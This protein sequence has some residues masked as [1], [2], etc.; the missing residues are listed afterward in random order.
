MSHQYNQNS[1]LAWWSAR[2][3]QLPLE[4]LTPA[5][6]G[7][8]RDKLCRGRSG[9]TV[10]R[11]LAAL[12]AV[13]SEA[14]REWMWL[15]QNSVRRVRRP[16]EARARV[17]FLS[18]DERERLLQACRESAS[19]ALYMVVVLALSTGA[20]KGELLSLKWSQGD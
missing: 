19:S 10:N 12:S 11:Y 20:R 16:P 13:L 15:E 5:I 14:V 9:S 2:L 6:I 4:E 7:E 1:Q 3:G 8:H 17:R 18:D